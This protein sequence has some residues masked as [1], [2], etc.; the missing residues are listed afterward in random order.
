[1]KTVITPAAI[2]ITA[3]SLWA[4]PSWAYGQEGHEAV[5]QIAYNELTTK[6]RA[7]VDRLLSFE[8]AADERLFR[9]GCRWPDRY[10]EFT[11]DL[12]PRSADHYIN[13]PRGTGAIDGRCFNARG[14]QVQHCLLKAIETDKGILADPNISDTDKL[15]ALKFLGHWLG[16]IHQPLHVSYADDRG[17]NDIIADATGCNDKL[18]AVWDTCIPRDQM[19]EGSFRLKDDRGDFG[20]RLWGEI[21]NAETK[22]WL[23][24]SPIDWAN[25]S[26]NITQQAGV[27]YCIMANG[28]CA[29]SE[30]DLAY[31]DGPQRTVITQ[32]AYE[33][34]Y[35]PI[36]RERI[37]QAG[38]RLG[39]L[40]NDIFQ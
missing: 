32:D 20:D 8:P 29:Y 17:G 26:Y 37:K 11:A 40:L 14:N 22:A 18:H 35:G 28:V 6:A 24:G 39:A 31:N 19:M 7:E 38:V 33:D 13:V 3:L 36:V 16:D 1:M 27:G 10:N 30:T 5:C 12:K 2:L 15:K 23:Q 21:T 34:R 4:K 25:E 9:V